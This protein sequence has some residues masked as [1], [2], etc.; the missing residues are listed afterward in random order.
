MITENLWVIKIEIGFRNEK[1]QSCEVEG[2]GIVLYTNILD[3]PSRII[4]YRSEL[5]SSE[6][7]DAQAARGGGLM[8]DIDA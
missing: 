8:N 6:R 4:A 1:R 3:D 7:Y 5:L 2:Y